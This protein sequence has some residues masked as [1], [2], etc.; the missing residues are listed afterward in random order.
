MHVLLSFSM[1][2]TVI[3]LDF[4]LPFVILWPL[5]HCIHYYRSAEHPLLGILQLHVLSLEVLREAV[6]PYYCLLT[7][8]SF[9]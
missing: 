9:I 1:S 2:V 4:V 7:H 8:I 6:Y 5:I 3:R